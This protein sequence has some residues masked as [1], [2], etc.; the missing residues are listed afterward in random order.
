MSGFVSLL[1]GLCQILSPIVM[2]KILDE[3][4]LSKSMYS[5]LV[6]CGAILGLEITNCFLQY[7]YVA[8]NC[9]IKK[10]YMNNE[11]SVQHDS[12]LIDKYYIINNS[13]SS[14]MYTLTEIFIW[15][16][17][18]YKVCNGILTVGKL[19]AINSYSGKFMSPIVGLI[20]TTVTIKKTK[21][22]IKRVYDILDGK[23]NT[24][25]DD[26][27]KDLDE[28][29]NVEF[30]S[31]TFSYNDKKIL[32]KINLD[33]ERNK[34]NVLVGNSGA[35]KT[36]ILNLIM[37]FCKQDSGE[38]L[39]NGIGLNAYNINSIRCKIGYVSQNM[40][41]FNDTIKNNIV[42]DNGA[43]GEEFIIILKVLGIDEFVSKLEMGYETVIELD[44]KN[45]SGGQCQKILI[46]REFFKALNGS[47]SMIIF[48]EP[49][50][51]LDNFSEQKLLEFIQLIKDRVTVILISHD[52]EC[53][54]E[55]E[56]INVISNGE[57]VER[58]THDS[59]LNMNGIYKKMYNVFEKNSSN[60]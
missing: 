54:K 29:K 57:I 9:K 58:G 43:I 20:D 5:I 46:A 27:L 49:T 2:Q 44:G 25:I 18:G 7:L 21:L 40:G 12:I 32:N 38:I 22:S 41:I 10:R 50:S 60:V 36:T 59:L 56:S 3:G 31:V 15:G 8:S 51:N 30:E 48:D 26:S 24:L 28:I 45:L 19:Y 4:I 34:I 52:L 13:L 35:G 42:L 55:A 39:I 53:I 16:I 14:I 37:G 17:G 47:I 23:K 6:W 33:I 1:G 11:E